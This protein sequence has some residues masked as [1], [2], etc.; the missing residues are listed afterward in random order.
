MTV[1][2]LAKSLTEKQVDN[3]IGYWNANCMAGKLKTFNSLVRL[4]DSKALACAT[5]MIEKETDS[6]VYK[7]AYES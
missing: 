4:G 2:E 1:F 3:V 7:I 6:S 5:V